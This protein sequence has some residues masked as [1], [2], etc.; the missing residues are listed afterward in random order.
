MIQN[1]INRLKTFLCDTTLYQRVLDP[2][3]ET[4]ETGTIDSNIQA[5]NTQHTDQFF[6]SFYLTN[7]KNM[8]FIS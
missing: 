7:V 8:N 5:N 1:C 2:Q 6:F 3:E 4:I